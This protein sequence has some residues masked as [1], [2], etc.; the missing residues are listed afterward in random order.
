[1]QYKATKLA[2][3]TKTAKRKMNNL[4]DFILIIDFGS[5]Y[6]HLIVTMLQY[7]IGV[8][9]KLVPYPEMKTLKEEEMPKGIIL[10]GGPQSVTDFKNLDNNWMNGILEKKIPILGVCFGLQFLVAYLGGTVSKSPNGGEFGKAIIYRDNIESVLLNGIEIPGY[11]WM[12]HTDVATK[13][14]DG[15]EVY[16]N[17]KITRNAVLEDQNRNIYAVQFH[18]E[19]KDTKGGRKI[20]KNFLNRCGIR[21]KKKLTIQ[22]QISDLKT[23]IQ[24]QIPEDENVLLA[25]S[26][27][28]DSTVLCELLFLSIRQRCIPMFIDHGMMRKGEVEEICERFR[29]IKSFRCIHAKDRFLKALEGVTDPERKRK[30]IGRAFIDVFEGETKNNPTIKWLAQGTIYPDVIESCGLNGTAKKIKSHHNVGGLP[31]I[32]NLKLLEPF[33][34]LFK[35][36][37]RELG[38]H[39][40]IHDQHLKRHP[41]PGPGL[42]I[43]IIGEITEEKI[44]ITQ[45]ADDIFMN[46]LKQHNLY[47]KVSQAYAGF[48][49]VKTVG[50]VGD[51]RRY[52]Y[53]IVLRAVKTIDFMTATAYEFPEGCLADLATE[54]INKVPEVAKVVYDITS[55]PP[56]TIE[57]E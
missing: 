49:P 1:M 23:Q 47:D 36:Q 56:S 8:Q 5:Q 26:G 34:Y 42:G 28:V 3:T 24:K 20:Y 43:R 25:V 16:G 29:H 6:T 35:D 19:V 46:F 55:K 50:V 18:P 33:K 21:F 45:E 7:K 39:L 9:V 15:F 32:L 53:T 37:V 27:G 48:F 31:D 44:R 2:K 40:E 52:G 13:I 12:S 38:K 41:F 4:H 57:L 54:I 14:P 30:I 22:N 10:S 11:V 51:N 17:T